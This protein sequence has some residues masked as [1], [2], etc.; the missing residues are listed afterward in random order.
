MKITKEVIS[1]DSPSVCGTVAY[2]YSNK[3]EAIEAIVKHQDPTGRFIDFTFVGNLQKKKVIKTKRDGE[4]YY[5]WGDKCEC[6]GAKNT[7]VWSY[8]DLN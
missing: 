1:I 7:G 8:L 4:D 3:K 6:C 5:Y 2:G